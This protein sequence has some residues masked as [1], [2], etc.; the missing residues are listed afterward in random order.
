L[1]EPPSSDPL[2]GLTAAALALTAPPDGAGVLWDIAMTDVV[3][4]TLDGTPRRA[5]AARLRRGTWVVDSPDGP[6]PVAGWR[7]H[8]ARRWC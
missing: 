4:A 7:S 6:V 8:C 3:T 2:T 5:A 1:S